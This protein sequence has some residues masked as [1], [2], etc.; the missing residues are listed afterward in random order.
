MKKAVARIVPA[1]T[2]PTEEALWKLVRAGVASWNG[3]RPLWPA[4]PI[5]LRGK[6]KLTSQLIV[7]ARR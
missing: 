6:G 3:G 5:R 4:R 2:D 1:V 7:E